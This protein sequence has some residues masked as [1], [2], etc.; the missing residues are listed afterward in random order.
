VAPPPAFGSGVVVVFPPAYGSGSVLPVEG[1]A[2][3]GSGDVPD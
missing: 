1:G 3:A 2:L